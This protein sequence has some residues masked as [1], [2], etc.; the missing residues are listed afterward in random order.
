MRAPLSDTSEAEC[1][2]DTA[3]QLFASVELRQFWEYVTTMRRSRTWADREAL[4]IRGEWLTEDLVVQRVHSWGFHTVRLVCARARDA[5]HKERLRSFFVRD[6]LSRQM[7]PVA[8]DPINQETLVFVKLGLTLADVASKLAMERESALLQRLY[9][10]HGIPCL[11]EVLHFDDASTVGLAYKYCSAVSLQEMLERGRPLHMEELYTI[12]TWVLQVLQAAH[13]RGVVHGDL[14]PKYVLL[15]VNED[16]KSLAPGIVCGWSSASSVDCEAPNKCLEAM[17]EEFFTVRHAPGTPRSPELPR[18]LSMYIAPEQLVGMYFGTGCASPATDIYR[19]ALSL[20]TGLT[21]QGPECGLLGV[22]T[23][24]QPEILSDGSK[25]RQIVMEALL[26]HSSGGHPDHDMDQRFSALLTEVCSSKDEL[27]NM[28]GIHVSLKPWFE[29]CL[30][31]EG[32]MRYQNAVDAQMGLDD[33]WAAFEASML[34][35]RDAS[36]R[37]E[38]SDQ[39][40]ASTAVQRLVLHRWTPEADVAQSMDVS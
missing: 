38:L 28:A 33:A 9:G 21:S 3:A 15:F 32:H 8:S 5:A 40:R 17:A 24:A 10:L 1:P 35:D 27:L 36:L 34:A 29:R 12:A 22:I 30:K 26:Q 23:P 11:Q 16:G 6:K 14:Q 7:N 18:G 37:E 13:H 31:R 25:F 19:L 20:K 2:K 4:K 39:R